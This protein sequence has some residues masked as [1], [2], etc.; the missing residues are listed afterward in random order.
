MS[1][2][3]DPPAPAP[4]NKP[5]FPR[6]KTT[7]ELLRERLPKERRFTSEMMYQRLVDPHLDKLPG[8]EKN[9]KLPNPNE[10]STSPT[11]PRSTM[12]SRLN[13]A[14]SQNSNRRNSDL[15][16]AQVL[17]PL[18]HLDRYRHDNNPDVIRAG[19]RRK[20][21]EN[22][23]NV[24]SHHNE[25]AFEAHRTVS[26]TSSKLSRHYLQDK[27]IFAAEPSDSQFTLSGG[28]SQM[29]NLD[30]ENLPIFGDSMELATNDNNINQS[31]S[32]HVDKLTKRLYSEIV[33]P[34]DIVDYMETR[35]HSD[36]I[37][38]VFAYPPD[39]V[40]HDPFALRVIPFAQ[41]TNF[42][43]DLNDEY[44]YYDHSMDYFTVFK[45]GMVRLKTAMLSSENVRRIANAGHAGT[46]AKKFAALQAV[47]NFNNG[48]QSH[49]YLDLPRWLEEFKNHRKLMKMKTFSK[50][51]IWKAFYNWRTNVRRNKTAKIKQILTEDLYILNPSLRPALLNVRLLCHKI[52]SQSLCKIEENQTYR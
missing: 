33:N 24:Q 29:S 43:Y 41:I 18:L 47:A 22:G 45:E 6:K 2:E 46:Q 38:V 30:H 3:P 32:H 20:L 42:H 9:Y 34:Q 27:N 35:E 21:F 10:K 8:L 13:S 1:A 25:P 4:P 39:H 5:L 49:E 51:R 50:F 16:R 17:P 14:S 26:T 11:F 31:Q 15:S 40:K 7:A 36:F 44:A 37:Y 19:N 23:V 28:D 52:S 48:E 12:G